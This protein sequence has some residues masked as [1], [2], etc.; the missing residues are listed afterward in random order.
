MAVKNQYREPDLKARCEELERETAELRAKLA[1]RR[2]REPWK[3]SSKL[4][5]KGWLTALATLSSLLGFL[6]HFFGYQ[7]A[8]GGGLVISTIVG[9]IVSIIIFV[10]ASDEEQR[11]R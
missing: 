6:W 3:N 5:L 10:I 2:E 4:R 8:I 11:G 9:V 1:K 7:T